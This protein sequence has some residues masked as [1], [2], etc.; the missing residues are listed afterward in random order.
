MDM[1]LDGG[2]A[3]RVLTCVDVVLAGSAQRAVVE[4]IQ[5]VLRCGCN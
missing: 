5:Y 1:G 2:G 3:F 4:T